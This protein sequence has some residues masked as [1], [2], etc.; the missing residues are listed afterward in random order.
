M[1]QKFAKLDY[2]NKTITGT[3]LLIADV[4]I[5]GPVPIFYK[6]K[7]LETRLSISRLR[8]RYR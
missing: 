8:Y 5:S 2:F 1:N 6:K 3:G 4:V 7:N